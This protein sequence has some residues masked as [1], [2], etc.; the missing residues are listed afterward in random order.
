MNVIAGAEPTPEK[1]QT[2]MIN[3][4]TETAAKTPESATKKAT[5][6]ARKPR[7]AKSEAK[8][9]KKATPAKKAAK[10]TPK[11]K[12]AA[13]AK[14]AREKGVPRGGS[15]TSQVIAMLKRKGG[16]TLEE[17]MKAMGWQQHTTRA[18]LSAGGS[19]TKK[20]GLTVISEKV[21]DKRIYSIKA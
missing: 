21:G 2:N 17:I 9:A 1:G 6:A 12:A 7:V 16:T 15:K 8:P 19:L 13:P 3:E 11:P 10:A 14:A 18:L 20:H 4:T 5:P